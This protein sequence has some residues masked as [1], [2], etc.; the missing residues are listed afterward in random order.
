MRAW[1]AAAAANAADKTERPR[2]K[3]SDEHP[4]PSR[5]ALARVWRGRGFHATVGGGGGGGGGGRRELDRGVQATE[6]AEL[7]SRS[8][9]ELAAAVVQALA[10][11]DGK[12]APGARQPLQGSLPQRSTHAG[13]VS[14]TQPAGGAVLVRWKRGADAVRAIAAAIADFAQSTARRHGARWK[15]RRVTCSPRNGMR[16][17]LPV[18]APGP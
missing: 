17:H 11:S 6:L 8:A 5:L 4:S 15:G 16:T 3:R 7:E 10:R 14:A 12:P 18:A 13:T 1:A 2:L 9:A